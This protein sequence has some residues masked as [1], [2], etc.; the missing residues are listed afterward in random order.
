MGSVCRNKIY[1][2][3]RKDTRA[4]KSETFCTKGT[5]LK[6]A[7]LNC[8]PAKCRTDGWIPQWGE[9]NREPYIYAYIDGRDYYI[10]DT[11]KE[12]YNPK[13]IV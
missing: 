9:F 2:V 4:K 10:Y 3:I 5:N 6:D 8:I 1:R 7:L 12:G 13:W 11:F